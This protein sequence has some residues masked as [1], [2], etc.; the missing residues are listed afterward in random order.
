MRKWRRVQ[1]HAGTSGER[2]KAFS[3]QE[4]KKIIKFNESY[5]PDGSRKKLNQTGKWHSPPARTDNEEHKIL[6]KN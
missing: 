6:A 1:G 4:E 3:E 5:V 2:A